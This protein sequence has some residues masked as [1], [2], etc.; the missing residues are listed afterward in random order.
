MQRLLDIKTRLDALDKAL[1]EQYEKHGKYKSDAAIS[2]LV[3]DLKDHTESAR[4]TIQG[5]LKR[6]ELTD[7]EAQFIEPAINDVYLEAIDKMTR[8]A[9]PSEELNQKV[10]DTSFTLMHWISQVEH[11]LKQEDL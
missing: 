5:Q 8:G 3:T 1:G 10:Y 6:G 7:F 2:H 4:K 9:K 11:G